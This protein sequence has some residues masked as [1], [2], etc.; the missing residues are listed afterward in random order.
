[1]IEK[2]GKKCDPLPDQKT[3]LVYRCVVVALIVI[4]F[5]K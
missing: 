4:L 5:L 1:M 2:F 3:L